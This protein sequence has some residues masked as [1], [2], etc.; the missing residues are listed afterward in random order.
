MFE[1]NNLICLFC[2]DF[3]SCIVNQNC[4]KYLMQIK[5]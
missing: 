4:T 2:V 1:Y 3:E 5:L